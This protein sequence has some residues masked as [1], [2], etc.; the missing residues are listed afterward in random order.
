MKMHIFLLNT[1]CFSFYS[2]IRGCSTFEQN[3]TRILFI[4]EK[5]DHLIIAVTETRKVFSVYLPISGDLFAIL[6]AVHVVTEWVLLP[7]LSWS[8]STL[9]VT[10]LGVGRH[11]FI[12]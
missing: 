4:V 2:N 1:F 10:C 6:K 12:N 5:T 8:Y 11:C 3:Q 7:V 9:K